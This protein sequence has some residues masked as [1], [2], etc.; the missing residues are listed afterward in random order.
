MFNSFRY[1]QYNLPTPKRDSVDFSDSLKFDR[2]LLIS[3]MFQL[4]PTTHFVYMESHRSHPCFSS[5]SLEEPPSPLSITIKGYPTTVF[6]TSQLFIKSP[7]QLS[8][9]TVLVTL[10]PLVPF[11]FPTKKNLNKNLFTHNQNGSSI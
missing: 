5:P 4:T 6:S 2:L 1:N 9:T 11:L 7:C 8:S 10:V 3:R